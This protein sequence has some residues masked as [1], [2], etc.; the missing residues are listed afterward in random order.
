MSA[1]M[2]NRLFGRPGTRILYL[3][4]ETFTDSY[5]LDLAAARGDRYGV[6]YGRALDPTRPAQSDYVLDPDH[7]ARAL[8]WLDGDRAIRRQA[9]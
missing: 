4:P 2:V 1:A 7:L 5:Y 6:C 9:A 3:A 8:A